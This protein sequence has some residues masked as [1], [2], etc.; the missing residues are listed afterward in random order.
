VS[1]DSIKTLIIVVALFFFTSNLYGSFLP[2]YFREMGLS[3][4]EI[5]A[6]LLVTFLVLGFL[7]MF[8][9]K[10]V[11][12]FERIIS[13]G[14]FTT[15]VFSLALIFI[16]NP[17]VLGITYGLSLATF[18]PSFNLLQFRVSERQTR[19]RTI[20]ILSSI[21]P[22][23]AGLAAPATGGLIIEKLG[24]TDLFVTCVVIYLI[25]F[26]FSTR[27]QFTAETKR[28]TIPKN[29]VFA[30]FFL[31]FIIAGFAETNWLPYPF[32]MYNIS[33]T[34]LSMGLVLTSTTIL[35][36]AINFAI[37]WRS[38]TKRTR[39]EFAVIGATLSAAWTFGLGFASSIGAILVLSLVSGFG[40]AFRTS[41]FAHYADCFSSEN[42]AG[43]LAMMEVG[44]MIGRIA[45]LAPTYYF[46]PQSN[47]LALFSLLGVSVLM[48]IPFYMAMRNADK[49][50]ALPTPS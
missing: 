5:I 36:A 12:N 3:L 11:K 2:I 16:K 46:I 44:L 31:T 21:I 8:L 23:L 48:L 17:L 47:Y 10:S 45:N 41:W 30:I 37:N 38:D 1:N 27:I 6:I 42:Y 39:V 4:A 28:F 25:A 32:F 19:A 15:M 22:S 18:W 43:L 24:F 14:I 49:I 29:R 9:L 20:S 7:P 33:G 50:D 13:V 40:N 34:V 26:L 35:I